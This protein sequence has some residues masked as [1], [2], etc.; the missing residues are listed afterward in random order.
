[1]PNTKS[2][3]RRVKRVK[4]QSLVNKLRR[5]RYKLAIKKINKLIE[6]K[7]TKEI[8]K[9]FPTFQSELM[10]IAKTGVVKKENASRKIARVSKKIKKI[11]K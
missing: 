10:K 2:A 9:F 7:D 5:S 1:M 3:I 6:K 8:N 4:R 11:N